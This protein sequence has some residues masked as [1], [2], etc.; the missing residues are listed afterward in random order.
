MGKGA[1]LHNFYFIFYISFLASGG[2][3]PPLPCDFT[4][5]LTYWPC[6]APGLL[7]EMPWDFF[8]IK[9]K[10]LLPCFAALFWALGIVLANTWDPARRPG[11]GII[12]PQY[13]Q[14]DHMYEYKDMLG[15]ILK[16]DALAPP[17]FLSRYAIHLWFW[18]KWFS[19]SSYN[20]Q[21]FI[22]FGRFAH[23]GLTSKKKYDA[24]KIYFILFLP[25]LPS[26]P[27]ILKQIFL[28]HET[29]LNTIYIVNH[30][31]IEK[32]CFFF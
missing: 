2:G 32:P 15:S 7:C 19:S 23:V 25:S 8:L 26:L 24:I 6:S 14:Y 4:V 30:L 27:S 22:S 11:N 1:R 12:P 28:L 13:K 20:L 3:F 9:L 31:K 21:E 29:S 16:E 18:V 5:L 17:P 10:R